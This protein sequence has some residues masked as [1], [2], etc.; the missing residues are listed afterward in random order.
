MDRLRELKAT[1]QATVDDIAID[2]HDDETSQLSPGGYMQDF[3][4]DVETVKHNIM[5]IKEAT[6][7][8]IEINQ[9]VLQ[10]KFCCY[11]DHY[12]MSN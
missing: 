6:K 1:S 11:C 3:F 9:N 7:K 8:I 10:V 2:I 12:I 4:A 5:I